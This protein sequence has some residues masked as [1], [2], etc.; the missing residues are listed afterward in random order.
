MLI[1]LFALEGLVFFILRQVFGEIN[2]NLYLVSTIIIIINSIIF[3]FVIIKY[4]KSKGEYLILFIS[5]FLRILILY[6]DIFGRDIFILPNSGA[7][8]E[9]YNSFAINYANGNDAERGGIYSVIV[10]TIYKMFGEQRILAQYLNLLLSIYTIIIIKRTM[11]SLNIIKKI[12][13]YMLLIIAFLPNYMI[14]SSLLLRESIVIFIIAFSLYF[15]VKWWKSGNL[16]MFIIAASLPIFTSMFHSGTIAQTFAYSL[17]FIFYKPSSKKYSINI[18]TIVAGFGIVIAFLLLNTYFD[19]AI[20]GKF[21]NIENV[22]DVARHTSSYSTGG[23]TYLSGQQ[24]ESISEM[25]LL[26]P[27]RMFYFIAS[28]LPWDWRGFNDIFAFLFSALL[29]IITYFITFRAL[30]IK[31]NPQKAIIIGFLIIALT[32]SLMFGWGVSNAGTALRHREKFLGVYVVM[33]ALSLNTI[34][35]K[36]SKH[37]VQNKLN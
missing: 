32:S 12:R 35:F 9:M 19:E 3:L 27:I 34:K 24:V 8:T 16:L 11:E 31:S 10:G 1:F 36:K 29:F 20:F 4:S 25:I 33:L 17:C 28:P 6:W 14:I 21:Q 7:D 13:F 37:N 30:K 5:Y 26:S 18:Q 2:N 22:S 15:F 23:S